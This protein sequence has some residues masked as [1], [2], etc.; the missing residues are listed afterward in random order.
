M[1]RIIVLSLCIIGLVGASCENKDRLE[2]IKAELKNK[3]D[4]NNYQPTNRVTITAPVEKI[5]PEITAPDDS[6]SDYGYDGMGDGYNDYPTEYE[7]P[8]YYYE[9]NYEDY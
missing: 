7:D 3:K 9:N 5:A 1:K 8:G 6:Y 4:D 2:E